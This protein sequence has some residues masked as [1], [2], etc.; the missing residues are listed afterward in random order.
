MIDKKTWR[1]EFFRNIFDDLK[2]S[3]IEINANNISDIVEATSYRVRSVRNQSRCPCYSTGECH[4]GISDMNCFLCPCPNYEV[5]TPTGG[6]KI[7]SPYGEWF[8]HPELVLDENP[9]GKVWDCN[10][11]NCFHDRK[12]VEKYLGDNLMKLYDEIFQKRSE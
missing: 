4:K 9:E 6:C 2:S 12:M 11:C 3:G 8:Y 1:L 5:D 7:N 10:G